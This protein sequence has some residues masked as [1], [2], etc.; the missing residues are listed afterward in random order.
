MATRE[1]DV[2]NAN[3]NI[4]VNSKTADPALEKVTDLMNEL[5]TKAKVTTADVVDFSQK[6]SKVSSTVKGLNISLKD[7]ANTFNLTAKGAKTFQVN[8]KNTGQ[9]AL[10][11][12]AE[13]DELNRRFATIEST[14]L[15]TSR[16]FGQVA[17]DIGDSVTLIAKGGNLLIGTRQA[18][19]GLG[20]S[21]NVA[22]KALDALTRQSGGPLS[23][24]VDKLTFGLTQLGDEQQG[25][26]RAAR[27]TAERLGDVGTAGQ[28]ALG[29]I[30][31][32]SVTEGLADKKEFQGLLTQIQNV[33]NEYQRLERTIRSGGKPTQE[34][35][36]RIET[37]ARALRT[38]F[39]LL[40]KQGIIPF[41]S[42]TEKALTKLFA[43]LQSGEQ[44]TKQLTEIMK[45]LN[46]E[47]EK[48]AQKARE[49]GTSN[50]QASQKGSKG[51]TFFFNIFSNNRKTITQTQTSIQ[52]LGNVTQQAAQK[53]NSFG[54]TFGAVF[55][56]TLLTN[57][58]TRFTSF[59]SQ[60]PGTLIG[61][62][63]R[64]EETANRFGAVFK[65]LTGEAQIFVDTLAQEVGRDPFAIQ[66]SLAS[67]QAFNVGLGFST[68]E[69]FRMSSS[70][71]KLIL[72]FASFN[73]ITDADATQRFQAALSGS[74]E[75]MDKF[76]INIKEAA[77]EQESFR[78]GINKT[79]ANLSEQ[80][81]TI[82][83]LSIIA[84]SMGAQGAIGDAVKTQDSFANQSKRLQA[85]LSLLATTIGTQLLPAISPFIIILNTLIE[86]LLPRVTAG[87]ATIATT[88]QGYLLPIADAL[89]SVFDAENTEVA[90]NNLYIIVVNTLN[91]LLTDIFNFVGDAFEWGASFVD[92]IANGIIAG[93]DSILM[94]AVNYVTGIISSF[95][96]P[97]SPPKEGPLSNIDKWGA[98]L[99]D[100]F[101]ESFSE[102]T[103]ADDLQ[104]QLARA[105]QSILT[106]RQ[107][108][109][110]AEKSGYVPPE[111]LE[112]LKLAE[113]EKANIEQQIKDQ[114]KLTK[115]KEKSNKEDKKSTK[116]PGNG[117]VAGTGRDSTDRVKTE[118]KTASQIRD[119]ALSVLDQQ[120]KDGVIKYEDY[121]K[122][123][124]KIE[125]KFYEDTLEEGNKASQETVNNLQT[126]QK[127]VES[128][129]AKTK[130]NKGGVAGAIESIDVNNL[131]GDLFTRTETV[132][133]EA[134]KS[135][136][137][138]IGDGISESSAELKKSFTKEILPGILA[139]VKGFNIINKLGG[140]LSGEGFIASLLSGVGLL[141]PVQ[142]LLKPLAILGDFIRNSFVVKAL[143][144]V[145]SRLGIFGGLLR[146]VG[147]FIAK[148]AGPLGIALTIWENW[149]LIVATFNKSVDAAKEVIKR[150]I[151][152]LGGIENAKLIFN[153]VINSA[154]GVFLRLKGIFNVLV[155]DIGNID[156]GSALKALFSGDF[157]GAFEILSNGLSEAF[158]KAFNKLGV[159][160]NNT[161]FD[162]ALTLIIDA[163][164]KTITDLVTEKLTL[165]RAKMIEILPPGIL[166]AFEEL[167]NVFNSALEIVDSV[168]DKFTTLANFFSTNLGPSISSM[169]D[170]FNR[171][172]AEN[173]PKVIII[174]EKIQSIVDK[175][176]GIF[177]KS[178]TT[179]LNRLVPAFERLGL[180]LS[181]LGGGEGGDI[182]GSI[183][184]FLGEITALAFEDVL[185]VIS[186]ALDGLVVAL[187]ALDEGLT[188]VEPAIILVADGIG[189]IG[190]AILDNITF[191]INFTK[192]LIKLSSKLVSRIFNFGSS[193]SDSISGA[194]P[195]AI[196][197]VSGLLD[198]IKQFIV[199]SPIFEIISDSIDF[200]PI[201]EAFENLKSK[202]EPLLNSFSRLKDVLSIDI[203]DV[204]TKLKDT[205]LTNLITPFENAIAKIKEVFSNLTTPITELYTN[206][207]DK[208]GTAFVNLRTALDPIITKVQSFINWLTEGKSTLAIIGGLIFETVLPAL[209][210]LR[211]ILSPVISK[212]GEFFGIIG[213]AAKGAEVATT[214]AIL[215]TLGYIIKVVLAGAISLLIGII[216][217]LINGFASLINSLASVIE[218]FTGFVNGVTKAVAGTKEL[219]AGLFTLD[220]E[221]I[222]AG[223]IALGEGIGEILFNAFGGIGTILLA[224]IAA[225][226][227]ILSGFTTSFLKYFIELYDELIGNSIIPDMITA[228]LNAFNIFDTDLGA[229]ILTI[230]NN[231]LSLFTDIG[232]KI[233]TAIS[234]S[235]GGAAGTISGLLSNLFGGQNQEQTQGQAPVN[236]GQAQQVSTTI[237]QLLP[238]ITSS[239]STLQDI[240]DGFMSFVNDG[241]ITITESTTN[242][243]LGLYELLAGEENIIEDIS[244]GVISGFTSMIS[245]ITVS[246]KPLVANVKKTLINQNWPD[247]GRQLVAGIIRGIEQNRIK[248]IEK[249]K[250]LAKGAINA[251]KDEL[252][253]ASPSIVFAEIGANVVEGFYNS[254]KK[255]PNVVGGAIGQAR[256]FAEKDLKEVLDPQKVRGILS[257]MTKTFRQN[258][259]Q[260]NTLMKE[261]F[262]KGGKAGVKA[263]DKALKLLLS[264]VNIG[265]FGIKG[266]VQGKAVTDAAKELLSKAF[267]FIPELTEQAKQ[268]TVTSL[269]SLNEQA[270]EIFNSFRTKTEEVRFQTNDTRNRLEE[271][272][273]TPITDNIL[274]GLYTQLQNGANFSDEIASQIKIAY[275]SQQKLN[276]ALEDTVTIEESIRNLKEKQ[277]AINEQLGIKEIPVN[278]AVNAISEQEQTALKLL[279]GLKLGVDSTVPEV[280]NS[281]DSLAQ[282]LINQLQKTLQIQSPSKVLMDI[283]KN[284]GLGL[285]NGVLSVDKNINNAVQALTT[286]ITGTAQLALQTTSSG[287]TASPN[288][289][290]TNNISNG[291]DLAYAEQRILNTIKRE[292]RR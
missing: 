292:I 138:A 236:T 198:K 1:F 257:S 270:A 276:G 271:A 191:V 128:I 235:L 45:V 190:A 126:L 61:A 180:S 204:L 213:T 7:G 67:L 275:L 157:G 151:D 261:S 188:L 6:L 68:E 145:I 171:F 258:F 177:V 283:G 37:E 211:T 23:V 50:Q 205:I 245:A 105:N 228:I 281:M 226:Y 55:G 155:R 12:K 112:K 209:T 199:S 146:L 133:K 274:K 202:F 288:I 98:G 212:I 115:E 162:D 253:I 183:L 65:D 217:G 96:E 161:T 141:K 166:S 123:K 234:T 47:Q 86:N 79:S 182:F 125:T 170:S 84:Q 282:G 135:I 17:R 34:T 185:D 103:F 87:F 179:I 113:K 100:T 186:V 63:S 9:E 46:K 189:L 251:A 91:T 184:R 92:Q 136:V 277:A 218:F 66:D 97:G 69:S 169:S 181:F 81:K 42:N 140:I 26:A 90:L 8:V 149:D 80:E 38:E 143:D 2:V 289:Y 22:A 32:L 76:G 39:N 272:F 214:T 89:R 173:G 117:K 196:S 210:N 49:A 194:G 207:K 163:A 247:I 72:D 268:Q 106:L 159:L 95:L 232:P 243:F 36:D 54:Q 74:S 280:L 109:I 269:S 110:D 82:L 51:W 64:A 137:V 221:R 116:G 206:I 285:V 21:S 160:F 70:I 56:G 73:N 241:M 284:A 124:L 259:D 4:K 122:E 208:L 94:E 131:L 11:A 237:A 78:I 44:G 41:G 178:G 132:G 16:S 287:G 203:L 154:K 230:V 130:K 264:G 216:T 147:G 43:N 267:G 227:E 114:E 139:S 273:K 25:L 286:G 201:Q 118:K 152:N 88:I 102:S 176:A 58:V 279:E 248:F 224:P 3:I 104:S 172:V 153:S 244:D 59:L 246:I 255:L 158:G 127:E 242:L 290:I 215:E 28:R 29:I 27:L 20:Q 53:A 260:I 225:I 144:L 156:F 165:L 13:I 107:D 263:R 233:V 249:V 83:R 111:L 174:V 256:D 134:G 168:R 121:V 142:A 240:F 262:T 250:Q 62:A 167:R 14:A 239:T 231:I 238:L 71:Q 200:T 148:L 220:S 19:F 278:E 219:L 99:L 85:N 150:F 18:F 195:S 24:I 291:V 93:A 40:V 229:L 15:N 192:E 48:Q 33:T 60:L 265:A 254:I 75:V 164:F 119:A 193:I 197:A 120:L 31:D 52:N 223:F 30:K 222:F 77:L 101:G 175:L 129:E 108:I 252:G 5:G 35:L 266:G 10:K 57:A 187:T